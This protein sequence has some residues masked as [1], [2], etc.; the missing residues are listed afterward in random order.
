MY[1]N[2]LRLYEFYSENNVRCK[3]A[4]YVVLCSIQNNNNTLVSDC[5]KYASNN[6]NSP[7]GHNIAYFRSNYGIDIFPDVCAKKVI[8]PSRLDNERHMIIS[9]FNFALI[10]KM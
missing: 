1:T 9:E 10:I 7:L 6:A 5:W 2:I 4:T 8:L 3:N